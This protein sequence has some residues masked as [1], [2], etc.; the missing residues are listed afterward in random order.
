MSGVNF[1]K[2]GETER[3]AVIREE[4]IRESGMSFIELKL[5]RHDFN[6][7]YGAEVLLATQH[8]DPQTLLPYFN[9]SVTGGK[10]DFV[11]NT[12]RGGSYCHIPDTEWNRD[13]LRSIMDNKV[14]DITDKELEA[15]IKAKEPAPV[16]S[17]AGSASVPPQTEEELTAALNKIRIAKGLPPIGA[18]VGVKPNDT[19]VDDDEVFLSAPP[20]AS[21]GI[22]HPDPSPA[23]TGAN[24][25]NLSAAN[26]PAIKKPVVPKTGLIQP[27]S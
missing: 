2:A 27:E 22:G 23:G 12:L 20:P 7:S 13:F 26:K 25:P 17:G 3:E 14:V 10:L 24:K 8:T 5:L 15:K 6:G 16:L 11:R 4:A 1:G 18:G 19:G 21:A 9:I